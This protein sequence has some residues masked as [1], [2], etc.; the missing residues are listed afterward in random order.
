MSESVEQIEK[1]DVYV[2]L[3][4]PFPE[5][6]LQKLQRKNMTLTSVKAQYIS[7]RLNQVFGIEGWRLE[8]D[9]TEDDKGVLC[10]GKLFYSVGGVEC[11][12][13]GV[14]YSK[15]SEDNDGDTYKGAM[16]DSISKA[17]SQIGVANDVFKGLVKPPGEKT[18]STAPKRRGR[19]PARSKDEPTTTTASEEGVTTVSTPRAL[20]NQVLGK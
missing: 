14:G 3:C 8:P 4:A 7:E 18:A 9:F 13:V 11:H 6:A 17:S 1:I 16:T 12:R 10:I 2:Q 5:E 19:G 15:W 20:I